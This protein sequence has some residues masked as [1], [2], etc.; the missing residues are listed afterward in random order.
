MTALYRIR[1]ALGIQEHI[2][3]HLFKMLLYEKGSFFRCHRDKGHKPHVFGALVLQLPSVY[4]GGFLNI[5]SPSSPCESPVTYDMSR[6]GCCTNNL[7]YAAFYSDCPHNVMEL[8]EGNRAVIVFDLA[9]K[10]G[11]SIPPQ[12][13]NRHVATE[14]AVRMNQFWSTPQTADK[15]S[16]VLVHDYCYSRLRDEG[17]GALKGKDRA[18][19]EIVATAVKVNPQ[20]VIGDMEDRV[21][22]LASLATKEIYCNGSLS[23]CNTSLQSVV[24]E[25][26][27]NLSRCDDSSTMLQHDDHSFHSIT[28]GTKGI[29]Q[30]GKKGRWYAC[31]VVAKD[32]DD[33]SLK[34]KWNED[35]TV[36]LRLPLEKFKRKRNPNLYFDT[37]L[38]GISWTEAQYVGF[39]YGTSEFLVPLLAEQHDEMDWSVLN[40][41]NEK[42]GVP[43]L[44]RE[45]LNFCSPRS[46]PY[47]CLPRMPRHSSY[48]RVALLLF[49][50][51]NIGRVIDS[52]QVLSDIMNYD[53]NEPEEDEFD[54]FSETM[55][56]GRESN[57]DY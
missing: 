48:R 42:S 34:V 30:F 9:V 50:K 28:I 53:P 33:R 5:W 35:C 55:F 3:A 23:L 15:F 31:S 22:S 36:T 20:F 19:A 12:P 8:T 24:H 1:K 18:V 6:N 13:A 49:P 17:I 10:P 2:Q 21:P 7:H 14:L 44:Q 43:L 47:T 11:L 46:N 25:E 38:A 40:S 32:I 41:E 54:D 29:G 45:T 26:L 51:D 37:V 39:P 4:Q 57:G 16:I 52:R 27:S 56:F